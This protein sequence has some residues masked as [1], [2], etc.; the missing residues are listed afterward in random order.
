M[1]ALLVIA[2]LLVVTVVLSRRA[3]RAGIH[4]R[5]CCGARQW[6]PDDLTG[7]PPDRGARTPS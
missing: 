7:T 5:S 3:E 1:V 4:L 6:P 2:A